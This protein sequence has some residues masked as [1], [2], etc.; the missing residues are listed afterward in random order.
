M[1]SP[2]GS[3]ERGDPVTKPLRPATL[4]R[5]SGYLRPEFLLAGGLD[6]F[7]TVRLYDRPYHRNIN[8]IRLGSRWIQI[9]RTREGT[10][11]RVQGAAQTRNDNED[12]G[13]CLSNLKVL[14]GP[15]SDFAGSFDEMDKVEFAN[16]VVEE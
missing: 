12:G 7:E 8:V 15:V 3:S 14:I 5:T 4:M 6:T 1:Q 10:E 2:P 11:W 16:P 13:G 9:D